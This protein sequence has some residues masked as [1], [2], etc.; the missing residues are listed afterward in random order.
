VTDYL[1]V[2]QTS[3]RIEHFRRETGVDWH[4]R[5]AEAGERVVLSSGTALDVSAVY[6][7]LPPFDEE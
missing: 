4:Y 5:V 6:E 1:L 7:G 2:S 3:V